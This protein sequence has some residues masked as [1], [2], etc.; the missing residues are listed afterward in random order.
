MEG[1]WAQLRRRRMFRAAGAYLVFAWLVVQIANNLFLPLGLPVRSVTL[2]IAALGLFFPFVMALAWKYEWS[3]GAIRETPSGAP[4]RPVSAEGRMVEFGIIAALSLICVALLWQAFFR[5]GPAQG[6]IAPPM[7]SVAVLPFAD[8][9]EAGDQEYFSDGVAEQILDSLAQT[10]ELKVAARTS[11]FAYRGENVDVREIGRTLNVAAVLEGSVRR[12]GGRVRVTAQLVDTANGY[13]LWSETFDR[14]VTDIFAVQDEI[15]EASRQA[16]SVAL[17]GVTTPAPQPDLAAYDLLLQARAKMNEGSDDS[18]DAAIAD[19]KKAIEADPGYAPPYAQLAEIY[20]I[21]V[22]GRRGTLTLPQYESLAQP[23]VEKA[24]ELDALLPDAHI[25]LGIL[26]MEQGRPADALRAFDRA[27]ELNPNMAL[28]QQYRADALDLL[29]RPAERAAA[30]ER[31]VSLDPLNDSVVAD[32]ARVLSER[33][34]HAGARKALAWLPDA[35]DGGLRRMAYLSDVEVNAGDFAAFHELTSRLHALLGDN[36]ALSF[37]FALIYGYLGVEDAF[38][39]ASAAPADRIVYALA[40]GDLTAVQGAA[41]EILKSGS[42]DTPELREGAGVALARLG[43]IDGAIAALEPLLSSGEAEKGEGLLFSNPLFFSATDL[44]V[45]YRERGR[46]A[47]AEALLTA[48]KARLAAYRASGYATAAIDHAEARVLALTGD[49]D[50]ALE[51]LK[52]AV[53]SGWRMG[54]PDADPA[55]E[56]LREARGFAAIVELYDSETARQRDAVQAYRAQGI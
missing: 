28:A 6:L 15:A 20:S 34:D 2:T 26:R 38:D 52:T 39:A 29:G 5:N 13:H 24:L 56:S 43:D 51:K 36:P 7:A 46:D 8:L 19:L 23:L 41:A 37:R 33:G 11:S 21:R 50:A 42:A 54:S 9:S 48:M 35:G 40:R 3:G 32:W 14:P 18:I 10:P 4:H 55:F 30:L 22:E 45:C 12:S 31:A 49:T 44:A 25:S 27:A 1:V 47:E 16:L 53:E 17:L